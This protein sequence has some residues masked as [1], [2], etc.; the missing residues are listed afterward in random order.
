M[1]KIQKRIKHDDS[2]TQPINAD[3]ALMIAVG[4][5][6]RSL[7]IT[8]SPPAQSEDLRRMQDPLS[9]I[10]RASR[11]RIRCV[12]LRDDWWQKDSG[13]LLAYRLD[14]TQSGKLCPVALLPISDTRYEL[15]DPLNQTRMPCN[16]QVAA[17]L[18]PTAYTFYRPLPEELKPIRLLQFAIRGHL[19]ELLVVLLTGIAATLLGM[20]TPQAT[21]ML[22]DHAI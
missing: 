10:A 20:I 21:A 4:A 11:I 2:I 7:G 5:V 3:A 12:T 17:T 16:S 1:F 18:A 13:A 22:I 15:V 14:D 6:G 19:K 9:A 8:I